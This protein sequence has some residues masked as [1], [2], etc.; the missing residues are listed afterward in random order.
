MP[1]RARQRPPLT[2]APS[3]DPP[4]TRLPPPP[5][6]QIQRW[7]LHLQATPSAAARLSAAVR[8]FLADFA[9]ARARHLHGSVLSALPLAERSLAGEPT[10]RDGPPL[11]VRVFAR[12]ER[13]D[14]G[15]QPWTPDAGDVAEGQSFIVSYDAIKD[16]V[17][18]GDMSLMSPRRDAVAGTK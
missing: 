6:S 18:R 12:V 3:R 5:P 14:L 13:A 8:R 15:P 4:D 2:R 11:A 1:Q 7:Y 17:A 16:L 9:G 10:L